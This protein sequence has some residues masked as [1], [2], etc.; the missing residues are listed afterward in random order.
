MRLDA[1]YNLKGLAYLG[2]QMH[3]SKRD[4]DHLAEKWGWLSFAQL[5]QKGI[6]NIDSVI[7]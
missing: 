1:N 6:N 2:Y 4:G 3:G 7:G 5:A